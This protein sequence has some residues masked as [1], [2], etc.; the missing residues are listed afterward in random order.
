MDLSRKTS[1]LDEWNGDECWEVHSVLRIGTS[2]FFRR[3]G[4]SRT[5]ERRS[6]RH[7]VGER[8]KDLKSK[9][10]HKTRVRD[11]SRTRDLCRST[12]V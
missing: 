11:R 2:R 1:R 7:V 5:G 4:W 8:R 12:R 10:S 9:R 6:E 3:R